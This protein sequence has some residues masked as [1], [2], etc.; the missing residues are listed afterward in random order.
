MH[1]LLWRLHLWKLRRIFNFK[2][3]LKFFSKFIKTIQSVVFDIYKLYAML[4]NILALQYSFASQAALRAYECKV[5]GISGFCCILRKRVL[6]LAYC[7]SRKGYWNGYI[8][9]CLSPE[10]A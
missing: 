4:G 10:L 3:S 1:V 5:L 6:A 7:L 9:V 8:P 2:K